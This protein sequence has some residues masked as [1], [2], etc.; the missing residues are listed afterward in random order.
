MFNTNCAKFKGEIETYL[1]NRPNNPDIKFN[2]AFRCLKIRTC[3]CQT[4]IFKH[5]GYPA[6]HILFV[7]LI[8]PLLK[9]KS[10]NSF[11][12]KQWQQWSAGKKDTFY[13]YKRNSRYRWRS[14]LHKINMQI[15]A[16]I[17]LDK[18]PRNERYFVLD[19][20][21]IQ[22]LGKKIENASY[23]FDHNLGHSVLG[24][25]IV[26]LGLFTPFGFYPLDFAYRFGKKQHPKGSQIIGDPRKSSGMRSYEAKHFTKL[27]LSLQMIRRAVELGIT[28]GYV[29]FDSWF[30]WPVFINKI[31]TIGDNIHVICRLKNNNVKYQYRGKRYN[32]SEIYQMIKSSFQKDRK[33][34]LLLKR[35][36]VILPGSDQ[37]S[38]IIFSKGYSEP[39][40]ETVSGSKKKKEDKWVAFLS[41]DTQLHSATIIAK[42]VKRW[43]IEVCFKECKQMLDLGKDQSNDFNA[44]VFA[45]TCSFLRYNL[46]NYINKFENYSTLGQLFEHIADESMVVSYS[47]RLWEFFHGLFLVSFSTIFDLFEINEDVQCYL[48]ALTNVY[49]DIAP[50]Q[51]CET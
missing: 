42:Y 14:F 3:M 12:L 39:S 10:V 29:M 43:P 2:Q 9:I 51:G 27:E 33:T 45:V 8:L 22:K 1:K 4:N 46:L 7:L 16:A 36:R 37:E 6:A 38:I 20:T 25:C 18:T 11:C 19:D 49:S 48:D 32:L 44:Q 40:V 28:P 34:G 13:R 17:E 5:D 26:T 15:F 47:H 23:V 21:I 50:F 31:R 30:S 24:F 35:V 41:T